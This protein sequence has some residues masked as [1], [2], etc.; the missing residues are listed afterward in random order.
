VLTGTKRYQQG[1]YIMRH[2]RV[3]SKACFS[4][5]RAERFTGQ[6]IRPNRIRSI[7]KEPHSANA[8]PILLHPFEALSYQ[9]ND[10]STEGQSN[11]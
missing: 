1:H 3:P 4:L 8:E 11:D 2:G 7:V 10:T 9:R 6:A 5:W